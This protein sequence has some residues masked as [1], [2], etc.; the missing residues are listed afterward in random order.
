MSELLLFVD[1]VDAVEHLVFR[2]NI[3]RNGPA[4]SVILGDKQELRVAINQVLGP[5]DE[6]IVTGVFSRIVD[7][8]VNPIAV[9]A[10]QADAD[11]FALSKGVGHSVTTIE[12]TID[13]FNWMVVVG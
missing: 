5:G 2:E 4:L 13:G 6:Q 9:F 7:R 12:T 8:T 1:T 3:D 11:A 10:T